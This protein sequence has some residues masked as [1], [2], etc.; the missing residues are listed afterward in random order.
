MKPI[1]YK[2]SV[3]RPH[4]K[5]PRHHGDFQVQELAKSVERF[6]QIRPVI[7]DENNVILAGHGLI[8]A[9]KSLGYEECFVIQKHNLSEDE[10]IK[11]LLADNKLGDLGRDDNK[12]LYDLIK[13]LEVPEIPG[14]D[15]DTLNKLFGNVNEAI[16][17]FEV[18]VTESTGKSVF[19]DEGSTVEAKTGS[20]A[21]I[22]PSCGEVV[23]L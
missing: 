17:N 7:I 19:N 4:P 2:I 12:G 1:K 8:M 20:K 21:I 22:C 23:T 13:E 5:N 18:P 15:T 9:M 6:G 3:L 16:E 11:L 10:K 14:F